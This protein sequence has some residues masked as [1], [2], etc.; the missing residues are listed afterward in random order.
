[1]EDN[2]RTATINMYGKLWMISLDKVS[3]QKL[4]NSSE[5]CTCISGRTKKTKKKQR[6]FSKSLMVSLQLITKEE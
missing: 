6:A 2:I 4:L 1:M 5:I 3:K